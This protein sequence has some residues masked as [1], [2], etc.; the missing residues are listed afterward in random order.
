MCG[1]KFCSMK[2]TQDIRADAERMAGMAQKSEE[3]RGKGSALY[4]PEGAEAGPSDG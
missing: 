4:L 1:P 3:F 2:I